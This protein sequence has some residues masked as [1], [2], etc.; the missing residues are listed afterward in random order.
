M[1][2]ILLQALFGWRGKGGVGLVDRLN[3][4]YWIS[5]FSKCKMLGAQSWSEQVLV[6][7]PAGG[8]SGVG[9]A[10]AKN[11]NLAAN[12]RYGIYGS[13]FSQTVNTGDIIQIKYV[14]NTG[15]VGS[16]K[17]LCAKLNFIK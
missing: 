11:I 2:T 17:G 8:A 4:G 3:L 5:S 1:F 15:V 16:P 10:L 12:N 6:W 13:S 14:S 9:V 7:V